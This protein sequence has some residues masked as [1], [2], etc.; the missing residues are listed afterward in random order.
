MD[1][2]FAEHRRRLAGQE[3]YDLVNN[4]YHS[5]WTNGMLDLLICICDSTVYD[6]PGH[7]HKDKDTRIDQEADEI[8]RGDLGTRKGPRIP[9]SI[10]EAFCTETI[11]LPILISSCPR[12]YHSGNVVS[13]H[14]VFGGHG[15]QFSHTFLRSSIS[16]LLSPSHRH[17]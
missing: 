6:E 17:W 8:G 11:S 4:N 2:H 14:S 9:S 1:W 7:K 3:V 5:L 10:A 16:P 15:Y 12:W 13:S